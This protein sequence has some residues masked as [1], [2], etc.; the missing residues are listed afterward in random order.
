[1]SR[2]ITETVDLRGKISSELL[3]GKQ[4]V[5]VAGP[6]SLPAGERGG[7]VQFEF[8]WISST[9]A[10]VVYAKDR[11]TLIVLEPHVEKGGVSW[12]CIT[13]PREA[14]PTI[15]ASGVLP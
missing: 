5:S 6:L 4:N 12:K 9:G 7:V 13:Y 2:V 3:A 10:V 1:M 14:N 11:V 8:G 15:Y